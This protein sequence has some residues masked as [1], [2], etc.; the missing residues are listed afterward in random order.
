MPQ[1]MNSLLT[2]RLLATLTHA[3]P[4]QVM[5][6]TSTGMSM[7]VSS[8]FSDWGRDRR[9][10]YTHYH[11][12][13]L[14]YSLAA[15]LLVLQARRALHTWH[16]TE[17][18]ACCHPRPAA[19]VHTSVRAGHP[20]TCLHAC[21]PACLPARLRRSGSGWSICRCGAAVARLGSPHHRC[22]MTRSVERAAWN[23]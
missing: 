19:H 11:T 17:T 10:R 20:P 3:L 23:R 5:T 8:Y 9:G 16:S 21:L 12:Q 14:L 22:G 2:Y 18:L 15:I 4:Y 13:R 1:V 7:L 6:L